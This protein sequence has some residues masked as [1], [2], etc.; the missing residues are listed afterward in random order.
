MKLNTEQINKIDEIEEIIAKYFGISPQDI[1]N[2]LQKENVSNARY[3][4]WYI[5][6]FKLEMSSNKIGKIYLYT[7]RLV[8]Y[9]YA[10]IKNGIRFHKFYNNIYEDLM[11][12][13]EP[14]LPKD[15]DRFW[16]KEKS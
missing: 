2:K 1:I 5:L 7:P 12:K 16:E 6:H 15:L 13:I 4:L 11:E 9:G 8:K 3:F 10:K 14:I